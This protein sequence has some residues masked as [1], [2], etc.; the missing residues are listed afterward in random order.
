MK[1]SGSDSWY[2]RIR[3][4]FFG[5]DFF[6]SYHWHSGGTYAV[7]LA[8]RL[9]ER[10]YEVFLDR[11]EYA[12]GDDWKHVGEVALRNTQRLV[13]IATREAVFASKP[14]EREV[15]LFTDRGRHCIPI[16]FGCRFTPEEQETFGQHSGQNIVLDRLPDATLHIQDD[17]ENLATGPSTDVLEKLVGAHRIMRRR[18]VRSIAVLITMAVL[19]MAAIVSSVLGVSA[20]RS[21][22]LAEQRLAQSSLQ[23]G[24][25]AI[26]SGEDIDAAL[27][28][29]A[30]ALQ[31]TGWRSESTRQSA[32][33]LIGAW[34]HSIPRHQLVHENTIHSISLD[35]KGQTL[36]TACHDNVRLWSVA[37]GELLDEQVAFS[38]E[39]DGFS[40]EKFSRIV[41]FSPDGATLAAA[42]TQGKVRLWDVPTYQVRG[43]LPRHSGAITALAFSP[44]GNLLATASNGTLFLDDERGN[45]N[46]GLWDVKTLKPI[47]PPIQNDYFPCL[48]VAISRDGKFLAIADGKASALQ[49]NARLLN[50]DSGQVVGAP[51]IDGQCVYAIA[52]SPD[53]LRLAAGGGDS[54]DAKKAW[55][56]IWDS[57]GA[58]EGH[59][60][61]HNDSVKHVSFSPNGNFLASGSEDGT[62]R[63]SPARELEP[64]YYGKSMKHSKAISALAFSY[65]SRTIATAS[66]D[67]TVC[68]WDV[69]TGG[70]RAVPLKHDG[71]VTEISYRSEASMLAT[72]SDNQAFVWTVDNVQPRLVLKHKYQVSD[73][74]FSPDG[75]VIVT[76]CPDLATSAGEV[77]LWNH[78]TGQ[79]LSD[80]IPHKCHVMH[81]KFSRSCPLFE[82][83]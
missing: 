76:A 39:D 63:L 15:I 8:A 61:H 4:W 43:Q 31:T 30:D 13:L 14:V 83:W 18:R 22:G 60:I 56:Q 58:A 69:L 38:P 80:P 48:A 6:V 44:E 36:A 26:Q 82:N 2:R 52:F 81:V 21:L 59:R 46:A 67:A 51:L 5:Y 24:H 40:V 53:G 17:I 10:G 72:A 29:Y 49:G 16:F 57:A 20:N 74:A 11:A 33:S 66:A 54:L 12:M 47:L 68:L 77:L 27:L 73:V 19:A 78:A 42:T 34:I 50:V 28:W 9:R 65:D 1:T 37:T 55:A 25:R 32:R 7:N 75:N 3:N 71:P 41:R 79:P 64:P 70:L 23:N 62:V 45:F 35:P